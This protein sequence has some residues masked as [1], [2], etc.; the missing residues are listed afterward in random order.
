M[1]NIETNALIS[2]KIEELSYFEA[3][4]VIAQKTESS[5]MEFIVS[6]EN[7]YANR[8]IVFLGNNIFIQVCLLLTVIIALCTVVLM[9]IVYK[10]FRPMLEQSLMKYIGKSTF[11]YFR[12][13]I[14]SIQNQ[15]TQHCRKEQ[16]PK[17]E[18]S[19]DCC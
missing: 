10:K 11:Q 12:E 14:T 4:H 19:T 8:E 18:K 15:E 2:S 1:T 5:Y 3:G 13:Q 17:V 16:K 6:S 7:D 9:F